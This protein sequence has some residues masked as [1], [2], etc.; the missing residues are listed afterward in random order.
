MLTGR[1]QAWMRNVTSGDAPDGR[2]AATRAV[3]TAD[4]D[5]RALPVAL[6]RHPRRRADPRPSPNPAVNRS[7]STS[8]ARHLA[9]RPPGPG[10]GGSA[11][12][13]ASPPTRD[14]FGPRRDELWRARRRLAGVGSTPVVP[15]VCGPPRRRSSSSRADHGCVL[16]RYRRGA[17]VRARGAPVPMERDKWLAPCGRRRR[18]R[19]GAGATRLCWFARRASVSLGC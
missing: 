7:T 14:G 16:A 3:L 18:P 1:G 15:D 5:R 2:G 6:S 9:Q 19:R 11:V 12:D 4:E 10:Y 17:R 8:N 13:H